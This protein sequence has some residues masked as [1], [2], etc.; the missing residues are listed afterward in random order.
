MSDFPKLNVRTGNGSGLEIQ[1]K[2]PE[3][4]NC[5]EFT[6]RGDVPQTILMAPWMQF[7]P[8]ALADFR[9]KMAY[10]I[11]RRAEVHDDLIKEV[12][13]LQEQVETLHQ[14]M[15]RRHT[16]QETTFKMW[17]NDRAKAG[18]PEDFSDINWPPEMMSGYDRV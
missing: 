2:L 11:A 6:L 15:D 1:C 17:K 10:E 12:T 7:E 13:H 18:F 3:A 4:F 16:T 8:A 14:I 9:Q 5:V